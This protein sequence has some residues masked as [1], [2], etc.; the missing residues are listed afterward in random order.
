MSYKTQVTYAQSSS[1]S[2]SSSHLDEYFPRMFFCLCVP[3][4]SSFPPSFLFCQRVIVAAHI[5]FHWLTHIFPIDVLVYNTQW[6]LGLKH[7]CVCLCVLSCRKANEGLLTLSQE[8]TMPIS[9]RQ[10][11]YGTVSLHF[12]SQ[13]LLLF[14]SA[15]TKV[16]WCSVKGATDEQDDG[17]WW[18]TTD[19]LFVSWHLP[20]RHLRVRKS[21][22]WL[23]QAGNSLILHI[24]L[25]LGHGSPSSP[26]MQ[27]VNTRKMLTLTIEV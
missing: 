16:A 5:I 27:P 12:A 4:C 21:C 19:H 15:M 17:I 23:F 9:I 2:S 26:S 10:L 11:A 20:Y 14:Y 18:A 24:K 7:W 13:Y 3:V 6:N 1:S 8:E 25:I 22:C